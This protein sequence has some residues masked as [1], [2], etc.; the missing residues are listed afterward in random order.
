[1]LGVI[2]GMSTFDPLTFG[3]VAV[4]FIAYWHMAC[5]I[6]ARRATRIQAMEALR[7]EELRPC[8]SMTY[9]GTSTTPPVRFAVPRASRPSSS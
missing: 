2:G 8:G 3:G 5:Y 9:V 1:M 6:P 7:Y 4:I